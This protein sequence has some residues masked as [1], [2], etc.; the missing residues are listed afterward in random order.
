VEASPVDAVEIE[1]TT[2]DT[3]ET[4]EAPQTASQSVAGTPAGRRD[5]FYTT[6]RANF[7]GEWGKDEVDGWLRE[8]LQIDD[9]EKTDPDDL[10][11]FYDSFKAAQP[12]GAKQAEFN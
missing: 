9:L 5:A 6:I 11:A 1:E 4:V 3:A 7:G 12:K 10:R 2:P 8:N